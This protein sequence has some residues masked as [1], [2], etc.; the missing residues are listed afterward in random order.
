MDMYKRGQF[1]SIPKPRLLVKA[2]TPRSP[3]VICFFGM[4]DLPGSGVAGQPSNHE[5]KR[6]RTIMSAESALRGERNLFRRP[7]FIGRGPVSVDL[8][9]LE[10]EDAPYVTGA[11]VAS[12]FTEHPELLRSQALQRVSTKSLDLHWDGL[13]DVRTP[14]SSHREQTPVVYCDRRKWE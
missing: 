4:A 8:C 1:M 5:S 10:V 14:R 13:E 7:S 9:V 12:T 3:T 11:L 6:A 2:P